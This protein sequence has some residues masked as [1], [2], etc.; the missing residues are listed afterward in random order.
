MGRLTGRRDAH[1]EAGQRQEGTTM[2]MTAGEWALWVGVVA[3][4]IIGIL[5][6]YRAGLFRRR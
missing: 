2:D 4:I 1:E 6:A 5:T 3:L